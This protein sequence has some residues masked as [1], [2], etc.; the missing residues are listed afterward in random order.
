MLDRYIG[1][2]EA[3]ARHARLLI[4]AA[5]HHRPRY[6]PSAQLRRRQN[7][8][9]PGARDRGERANRRLHSR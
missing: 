5:R 1:C 6:R 9:A 7:Q 8:A 3:P 4:E 2:G